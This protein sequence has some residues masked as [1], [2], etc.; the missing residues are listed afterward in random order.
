MKLQRTGG[1]VHQIAECMVCDKF[2]QDFSTAS[3]KAQAH[4]RTT[5]H[6]VRVET[7]INFTYQASELRKGK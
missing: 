7:G 2:W 3:R 4:A 6:T 5:G 1:K